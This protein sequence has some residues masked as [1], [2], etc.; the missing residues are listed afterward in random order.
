MC[1]QEKSV[2]LERDKC[3]VHAALLKLFFLT[4]LTEFAYFFL[5]LTFSK[6]GSSIL[7]SLR[8]DFLWGPLHIIMSGSYTAADLT[9]QNTVDGHKNCALFHTVVALKNH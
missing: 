2:E 8:T 9:P 5:S 3:T 6:L 4:V 1:R 7:A